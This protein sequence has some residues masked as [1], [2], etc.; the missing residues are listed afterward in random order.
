MTIKVMATITSAV[1]KEHHETLGFTLKAYERISK[2]ECAKWK[3][4]QLTGAIDAKPDTPLNELIGK[5]VVLELT[6]VTY[7][8]HTYVLIRSVLPLSALEEN[9]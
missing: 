2:D 3:R 6:N 7:N 8:K 9:S 1:D 5:D 4:D